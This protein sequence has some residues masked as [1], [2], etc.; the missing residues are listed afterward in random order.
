MIMAAPPPPPLFHPTPLG[1]NLS[2]R[3]LPITVKT[4]D[5]GPGGPGSGS[6]LL[7]PTSAGGSAASVRLP[8]IQEIV[9]DY[10]TL[11]P[12]RSGNGYPMISPPIQPPPGPVRF[13]PC[14]QQQ[15]PQHPQ[16][17]QY[18]QPQPQPQQQQQQQQH[19]HHHHYHQHHTPHVSHPLHPPQAS[20]LIHHSPQSL[21][22]MSHSPS[23]SPRSPPSYYPNSFP[24][25]VYGVTQHQYRANDRI[26]KRR[27]NLPR[28]VTDILRKWLNDHMHHPYPTEREK[29][30]LMRQTGLTLNQISNWFINA[31][32]RR[33]PQMH[34]ERLQQELKFQR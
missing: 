24:Y 11:R 34:R 6:S 16:R 31:R 15:Q 8:S 30:E 17:P 29:A 33:L 23:A 20:P 4:D 7:T 21:P 13:G 19:H 27:G 9:P 22:P 2:T 26:K 12:D 28:P 32:R 25:T 3:S 1:P 14:Q 10:F 18:A 5:T